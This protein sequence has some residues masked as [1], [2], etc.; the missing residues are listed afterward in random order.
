[1][2]IHHPESMSGVI[3]NSYYR[4]LTNHEIN[5]NQQIQEIAEFSKKSQERQLK[6]KQEEFA[7]YRIGDT[8]QY[9]YNLGYSTPLQE[10]LFDNDSC[11][12]KAQITGLDST[13]YWIR[14]KLIESCGKKGIINYDSKNSYILNKK[15]NKW[16]KDKKRK[17]TYMK[18]GQ[19]LWFKYS[20]WETID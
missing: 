14:V 6:L 12:A 11:R 16:E 9:K 20:D 7:E 2:G 15:T 13:K 18:T 17:I 10:Q 1:M 4:H 5:F 3:L 8:I 19:Q